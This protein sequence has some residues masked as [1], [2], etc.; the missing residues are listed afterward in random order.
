MNIRQTNKFLMWLWLGAG[1]F[2]L[3]IFIYNLAGGAY[4]FSFVSGACV[5]WASI[6]F[7]KFYRAVRNA[8]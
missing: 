4:L 6:Y 5:V 7:I 2:N 1:V 3:S 8:D